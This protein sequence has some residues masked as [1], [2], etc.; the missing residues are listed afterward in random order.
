MGENFSFLSWWIFFR[1]KAELSSV[2]NKK[3]HTSFSSVS[4]TYSYRRCKLT[5]QF[6]FFNIKMSFKNMTTCDPS[7]YLE[8][9]C[10]KV[11]LLHQKHRNQLLQINKCWKLLSL[12]I[13]NNMLQKYK[14]LAPC[15]LYLWS[16]FNLQKELDVYYCNI[17]N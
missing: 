3:I 16:N 13:I 7:G 5:Y 11:H 4:F 2:I 17:S 15:F 8:V 14:N 9:K 6:F 1:E 10:S 12:V